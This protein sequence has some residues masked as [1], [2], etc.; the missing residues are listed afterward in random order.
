[1]VLPLT[2]LDKFWNILQ[3]NWAIIKNK[4]TV[5]S[6]RQRNSCDHLIVFNV[7]RCY[8]Y[9]DEIGL[10]SDGIVNIYKFDMKISSQYNSDDDWT[11]VG[12]VDSS[13]EQPI[14]SLRKFLTAI[15]VSFISVSILI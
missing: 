11:V 10:T 1:M 12:S 6:G 2:N 7:F 3:T 4:F 14:P 5:P 8:R 13:E 9:L 15:Q